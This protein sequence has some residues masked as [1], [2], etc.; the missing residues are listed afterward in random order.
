MNWILLPLQY[1][2]MQ[3]GMLTAVIVG[4]VCA[5]IGCFVVLRS[6]SFL[7][8]AMAH[9][10]LPGVAIAYI[11]NLNLTFGALVASA[12]AALGINALSSKGKIKEDTAIGIIFTCSLALGV[13][14]I[15]SMKSYTSDLSHILFGNVLGI[16][17]TDLMWTVFLGVGIITIVL[18]AFHPLSIYTFDPV[19]AATLKINIRTLR[20][21]L[22][23]LIAFTIVMALQSVGV[24][25]AVAMLVIPPAAAQLIAKR[26]PQMLAISAGIGGLSGLLGLY[27]SYFLNIASGAAV[28]LTA[29]I[30]F[31]VIFLLTR[32]FHQA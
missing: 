28:V 18:K 5:V 24:S 15:S 1:G 13:A 12:I 19:F 14:L 7:G 10:I 21:G 6:M 22:F 29:G 31:G 27:A 26:L 23:L 3:R 32:R 2:F 11:F 16:S 17:Q 4:I 20:A 9:A 30:I 8:D 25:L